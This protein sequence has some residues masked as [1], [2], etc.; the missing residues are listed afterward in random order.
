MI[1]TLQPSSKPIHPLARFVNK[2]TAALLFNLKP[3]QIKR[4]ECWRYVVYVHG[5]GVSCFVSYADF[6]PVL[7]VEPPSN[8]DFIY[9]RKRWK[10]TQ[11][12]EKRK[13]APDFWLKFFAYQFQHTASVT[14]LFNWGKLVN[15]VKSLL[16]EAILDNLREVYRQE[17]WVLENF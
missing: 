6:P 5:E 7:E 13:Q 4:V 8:I 9:W 2:I 16:S 1:S 3:Q 14:Q 10:K 15:L 11:N 17:K 12:P